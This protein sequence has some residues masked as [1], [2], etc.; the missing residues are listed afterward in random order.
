MHFPLRM[1]KY[2]SI[3]GTWFCW[4]V[5]TSEKGADGIWDTLPTPPLTFDILAWKVP[6]F[7]P[8]VGSG[9]CVWSCKI[10]QN[11][12]HTNLLR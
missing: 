5:H 8:T 1:L 11:K 12:W 6:A 4:V 7:I 9:Y 2:F 3:L 10:Y